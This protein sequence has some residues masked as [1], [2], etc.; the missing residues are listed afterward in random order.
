MLE[1]LQHFRE[2]GANWVL[3]KPFRIEALE[4]QLVES[5]VIG[6][7]ESTSSPRMVNVEKGSALEGMA[8]S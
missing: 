8:S 1:D 4:Q 6:M 5:G 7:K 2:C 3:P